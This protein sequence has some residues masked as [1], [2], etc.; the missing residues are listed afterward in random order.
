M[1]IANKKLIILDRDG[2][3]NQDSQYYIKSVDEFIPLPGSLRAIKQLN[4]AGKRVAVATNQSG[5]A[6]GLFSLDT[7]E[8]QISYLNALLAREHAYLDAFVYCPHGPDDGCACRKPKAGL[9][10]TLLQRFTIDIIDAVFIGDSLRDLHAAHRIGMDA[11]LVKTGKGEKMLQEHQIDA[12]I[13]DDL[14]AVVEVMIN[15]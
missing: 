11:V 12:P 7:L 5:I 1:E 14:A 10:Q 8:A 2:V 13:Y 3:I 15:G 6:R 4:D 9:L